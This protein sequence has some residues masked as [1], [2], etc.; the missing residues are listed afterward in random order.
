EERIK[1][2]GLVDFLIPIAKGYVTDR[3]F[4][5]C[6]H[7]VQVYGGYGYIKEYPMEQ[8]V[9]DCRI[10]MIYE[11]TNGIMAMTLLGRNLGMNEGKTMM[12]LFAEIQKVND[13]A[14]GI[15]SLKELA[16]KSEET[17]N[18][19]GSV[20]MHMG[21]T[22]MSPDVL[23]A[24]SFA[25][26]FMEVAGDVTMSWML[27]WRAC[28]AAEMLE[29]D[30]PKKDAAFYEGQIKSADFFINAVLPVTLGKMNAILANSGAVVEIS[31]AS[32]GG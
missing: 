29:K 26:P 31:E 30:A 13:R 10:T 3:S 9:R 16:N 28:I 5:V 15:S 12:D 14:K 6:N 27:L 17:L 25:Y 24:F 22:A 21:K 23:K 4:E 7:G 18:L 2:Q 20:A 32:F 1:Y 19:L 8:L 11:G